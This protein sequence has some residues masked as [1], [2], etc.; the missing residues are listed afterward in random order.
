MIRSA[1]ARPAPTASPESV[2]LNVTGLGAS[3]MWWSPGT[4]GGHGGFR[5][6]GCAVDWRH[7]G[8]SLEAEIIR[9]SL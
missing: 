9:K 6:V 8:S 4:G 2:M 1:T 3:V 5:L 7:C